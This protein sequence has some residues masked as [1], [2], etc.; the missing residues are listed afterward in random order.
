MRVAVAVSGGRD[1][2]VL[3][4]VLART[5]G[6]HGATLQVVHVHHGWHAEADRWEAFVRGEA[7]RRALPFQTFR[8]RLL[9]RDEASAREARYEVFQSLDVDR[10]AL[11]HHR[12]DQAETVLINLLR[13]TGPRG[14]GGMPH[15][16]GRFVRPFLEME[17]EELSRWVM[18]EDL[19]HVSDPSNADPHYLRARV[20]AEL[21]P[22]MESIRSG[23]TTSLARSA[24]YFAE[25][26]RWLE[27][28]ASSV[29]TTVEVLQ[30]APVPLVRR[31]LLQLMPGA[32]LSVVEA[33]RACIDAG[34][35]RV[36]LP[37]G[38]VA[39]IR[40]GRLVVERDGGASSS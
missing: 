1:S 6:M 31:R 5:A 20:R 24:S 22:L 2:M 23:A 12:Q 37:G 35:G 16:R 13:G 27:E 33:V 9:R 15:R 34:G 36:E 18:R 11:A 14:W 40:G 8:V 17:P 3:M 38:G 7:A 28:Q 19:D 30:R 21:L 10:V 29:P 39:H 25:E 4:D 32:G 26:G